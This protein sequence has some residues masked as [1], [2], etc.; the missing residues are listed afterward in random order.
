MS[1]LDLKTQLIEELQK[2]IQNFEILT[3]N[4]FSIVGCKE[5]L[6]HQKELRIK[7]LE[8]ENKLLQRPS[9]SDN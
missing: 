1:N 8:G 3:Q 7:E 4:L 5:Y 9:P 2:Q 6:L